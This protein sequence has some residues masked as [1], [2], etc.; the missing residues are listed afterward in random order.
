VTVKADQELGP[1]LHTE[2]SPTAASAWDRKYPASG[3]QTYRCAVATANGMQTFA[4]VEAATGD[5]AAEKALVLY[6]GAKIGSIAPSP[7]QRVTQDEA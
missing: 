1:L 7:Q 3:V 6:P 5:E 4:D 2:A